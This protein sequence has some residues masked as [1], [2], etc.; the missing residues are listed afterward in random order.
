LT[1]FVSVNYL[2]GEV[3][4]AKYVLYSTIVAPFKGFR[5]RVGSYPHLDY[6]QWIHNRRGSS[7]LIDFHYHLF[8]GDSYYHRAADDVVISSFSF[9][10]PYVSDST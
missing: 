10:G 2:R 6:C 7:H 4:L 5:L 9:E 1:C 8:Y 3:E